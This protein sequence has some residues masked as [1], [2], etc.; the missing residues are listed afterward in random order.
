MGLLN[1]IL[2]WVMKKRIHQME[3]FMKYPHEVQE[4]I[5]RKLV[6]TARFT[7]FGIKYDF[8]S[9]N[10]YRQFNDRLPVHSYEDIYPYIERLMRGEQNILWPSEIKWFSKSSGTTNARSK[11]RKSA[12]SKERRILDSSPC[13]REWS[14]NP[15]DRAG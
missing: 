9:I 7:E 14:S 10:S 4:E 11:L 13:S 3:L 8:A 15:V 12:L 1:S 5:F 6:N 2:T